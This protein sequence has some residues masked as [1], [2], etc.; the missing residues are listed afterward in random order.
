MVRTKGNSVSL[1]KDEHMMSKQAWYAYLKRFHPALWHYCQEHGLTTRVVAE[2][3]RMEP[4]ERTVVFRL[5][6]Q[7]K[8]VSV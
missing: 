8:K 5:E 1:S 3:E 6:R 2:L 4:L 7:L